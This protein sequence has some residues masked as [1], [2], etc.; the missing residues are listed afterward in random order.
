MAYQ[1][2][3]DGIESDGRIVRRFSSQY[4]PVLVSNSF[5][6]SFSLY[7]ERVGAFSIVAGNADEAARTLSQLKRI[8]RTNY[9][10]P[11]IYGAKI[12]ATVLSDKKLRQMWENELT[13]MR[14]R[15][16]EMR[17]KL[18]AELTAR[19]YGEDFSFITRQNGMFSY[20]GLIPEQVERLKNEFSVYIVS[21][22]RIC[23]AALNSHN[24][25][26]VVSA[27]SSVL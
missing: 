10:N 14:V 19:K 20:S 23:V 16:H 22:G 7:G 6:K 24:L 3:S 26:Y 21:T 27:I 5:S 25:D 13:G 9:S 2:F 1:G 15:I 4:T 18:A 12:V 17:H 11:P 8:I